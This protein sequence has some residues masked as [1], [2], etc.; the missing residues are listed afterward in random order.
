VHTT[1]L[2]LGAAA[3]VAIAFTASAST[4][5]VTHIPGARTTAA[6]EKG[7]PL[8]ETA[9]YKVHASRRNE[10]GL[11]E[12]HQ[13]DTDILYVL[14]GT[15]LLVTGGTLAEAKTIAANERR[16]PRIDGGTERR[17]AKGDVVIVPSGVPHW[18]KEVGAPFLYYVVKVTDPPGGAR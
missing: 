7:A 6:F 5:D 13:T 11:A 2:A 9:T 18:F 12:V 4:T 15:A 8:I 3:L 1:R 17:L 10:P 14:E 16:G